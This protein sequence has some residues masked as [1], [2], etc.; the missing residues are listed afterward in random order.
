MGTVTT[1]T[2]ATCT[3]I[4]ASGDRPAWTELG[5]RDD[6]TAGAKEYD[7]NT[8]ITPSVTAYY[9]VY[10]GNITFKSGVNKATSETVSGYYNSS[11]V[12]STITSKTPAAI[13]A[14]GDRPA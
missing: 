8:S 3:D 6:T 1:P 12:W 9:A 7:F 13:S 4:S 2:A 14:S 10:S 11:N 5:W